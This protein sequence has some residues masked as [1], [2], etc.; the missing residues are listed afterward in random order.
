[1]NP[2]ELLIKKAA[3]GSKAA[4]EELV[5][6]YK[7]YVF[8]I[9][10]NFIRDSHQAENVA[11]EVFLQVYISLP[12]YRYEGFRTWIGRIA[13][14]KAIDWKRKEGRVAEREKPV[15]MQQFSQ[16]ENVSGRLEDE[17][18]LNE[19]RERLKVLCDGLP[20]RYR[21]IVR[22]FYY[23]GKSYR[24]IAEEEGI[25]EKTVESRLYRARKILKEKWKEGD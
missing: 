7:A 18:V 5:E 6:R 22:D 20:P 13:T 15:D 1:M 19:D 11:Q 14:H 2:E 12:R 10:L 9:I 8:A 23:E 17:L 25:A 16:R 24:Q 3:E 21:T 4:F